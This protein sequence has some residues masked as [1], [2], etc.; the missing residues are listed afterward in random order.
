[1]RDFPFRGGRRFRDAESGAEMLSDAP[2]ARAGFIA[3][4]AQARRELAVRLAASGVQ[5]TEYFLDEAL[6]QP[7]R[8]LFAPQAADR[9]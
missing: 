2:S 5:R 4:F 8:R 3:A 6:D 7:L 9:A 1:E